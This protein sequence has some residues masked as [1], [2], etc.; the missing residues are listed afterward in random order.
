MKKTI[1]SVL[2]VFVFIMT[3]SLSV[4]AHPLSVADGSQGTVS[5]LITIK[6]PD[7]AATSTVK[8]TYSITGVGNEGVSI[9]IYTYNGTEF[10]PQK[11]GDDTVATYTIGSSGVFYRQIALKEG[12]NRIMVRAEASD[13]T[14]QLSYLS[15]TVVN[16][17]VM[18]DINSFS[19]N[20]QSKLNGWLN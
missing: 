20:M 1:I 4:F 3:A 10:V 12:E 11:N 8:T 19:L 14:Y 2:L 15:I 13:G 9:C 17:S 16:N 7:S 18:T 6:K 5:N